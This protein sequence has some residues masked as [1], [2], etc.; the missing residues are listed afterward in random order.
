MSIPKRG[1]KAS[2]KYTPFPELV[3]PLANLY[4]ARPDSPERAQQGFSC[5]IAALSRGWGSTPRNFGIFAI[6]RVKNGT[7][8]TGISNANL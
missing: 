1:Y 8:N 7:K 6:L 4:I 2:I 3:E 5:M